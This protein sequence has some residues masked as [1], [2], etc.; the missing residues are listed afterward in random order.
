ME[1]INANIT[2]MIEAVEKENPAKTILTIATKPKL[3]PTDDGVELN[4]GYEYEVNGALPEIADGIAK[5]AKELENNGFEQG[6]A[7]Y[8]ITLINQFFDKLGG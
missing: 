6:S 1:K 7:K 2:E 3:N 5:F 8:F 4:D